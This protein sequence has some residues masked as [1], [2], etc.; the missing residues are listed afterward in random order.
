MFFFF[1][2]FCREGRGWGGSTA[3]GDEPVTHCTSQTWNPD[4]PEQFPALSSDLNRVTEFILATS[5]SGDAVRTIVCV[6]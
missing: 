2:M 5:S 4:F 6:W 1:S 3:G